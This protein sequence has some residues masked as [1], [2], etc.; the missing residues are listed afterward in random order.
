MA[1]FSMSAEEYAAL[2]PEKQLLILKREDLFNST[3]EVWVSIQHFL[4]LKIIPLPVAMPK[5]NSGRGEATRAPLQGTW[6]KDNGGEQPAP[7]LATGELECLA[8][9]TAKSRHQPAPARSA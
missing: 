6:T 1:T 7:A 4:G 5:A 8:P 2:F 9:A 3:A